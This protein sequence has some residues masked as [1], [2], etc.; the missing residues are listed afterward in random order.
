MNAAAVRSLVGSTKKKVETNDV[1]LLTQLLI[2][3]LL[4]L[5][6]TVA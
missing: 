6:D 1:C 3:P 5:L 2:G 4:I